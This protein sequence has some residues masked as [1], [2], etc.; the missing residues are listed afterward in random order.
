MG[1]R[2]SS[3]SYRRSRPNAKSRTKNTASVSLSCT[4]SFSP[5]SPSG[6]A[7]LRWNVTSMGLKMRE[8]PLTRVPSASRTTI[9]LSIGAPPVVLVH[10]QAN[11]L[12]LRIYPVRARREML[13]SLR[14]PIRRK[15][16]NRPATRPGG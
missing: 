5:V 9:R 10:R 2:S 16:E 15:A 6:P 11:R 1:D 4:S 8:N 14:E 12:P 7:S 13:V 3:G